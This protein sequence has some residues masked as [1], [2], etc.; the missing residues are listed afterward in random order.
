M[1]QFAPSVVSLSRS[2][3]VLP[4]AHFGPHTASPSSSNVRFRVSAGQAST[5]RLPKVKIRL[6]S[7]GNTMN[8][9]P[10]QAYAQPC[11]TMNLCVGER[12][13][14]TFGFHTIVMISPRPGTVD[15]RWSGASDDEI[16]ASA[17]GLSVVSICENYPEP[18][19]LAHTPGLCSFPHRPEDALRRALL[20]QHRPGLPHP[21]LARCRHKTRASSSLPT[22]RPTVSDTASP[23]LRLCA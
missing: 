22:A 19:L 9:V 16:R 21:C 23:H 4:P 20:K 17:T 14:S 8:T 15:V 12:L 11:K 5:F 2:S 7:H 18:R 6:P 13:S 1:M 10:A 3:A